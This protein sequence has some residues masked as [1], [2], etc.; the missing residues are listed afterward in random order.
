M[1]EPERTDETPA[2]SQ[3]HTTPK[4]ATFA[5]E[6]VSE[7]APTEPGPESTLSKPHAKSKRVWYV[8]TLLVLVLVG[9]ALLYSFNSTLTPSGN[10]AGSSTGVYPSNVYSTSTIGTTTETVVSE[11]TLMST[12]DT[13]SKA[14]TTYS[15]EYDYWNITV[16]LGTTEITG[17]IGPPSSQID[18]MIMNQNQYYD[19]S[20]YGGCAGPWSAEVAVYGLTS[21]YSL[22][23]N[24]PAPGWYYFIFF[25]EKIG[26]ASSNVYTPFVLI[27]TVN[28]V[29]TSTVVNVVTN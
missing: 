24:N 13:I 20:H 28:Q 9:G 11:S 4:D 6:P 21:T 2:T 5:P 26:L 16:S 19:F 14:P 8:V 3:P 1:A 23:W 29:Q 27:A 18:F 7:P 12:T 15:C 22:N 25:N 10:S 17:T